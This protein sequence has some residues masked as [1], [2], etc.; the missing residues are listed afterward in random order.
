MQN[1]PT[2]G[3]SAC[4]LGRK[5]RYNGGDV[6]D[7]IVADLLAKYVNFVP[8]CPEVGIGLPVPREPIRLVGNA[9]D[10]QLI[11]EISG[12]DL[13]TTMKNWVKSEVQKLSSYSICGFIFKRSSPSC[14]LNRVRLWLKYSGAKNGEFCLRM[15]TGMFARAV[16]D[17]FSFV[18]MV[19]EDWLREIKNVDGFLERVFLLWRLKKAVSSGGS[20][21]LD[22]LRDFNN[23][24][25][26]I[27]ISRSPKMAEELE[28]LL[29]RGKISHYARCGAWILAVPRSR[30][31]TV[32]GFS[33]MMNE[34][35]GNI[36]KHTCLI[37]DSLIRLYNNSKMDFISFREKFRNT[38]NTHNPEHHLLKQYIFNPHP[39]DINA[40]LNFLS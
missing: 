23:R 4:L 7:R 1:K 13:T 8:F 37:L 29:K 14:G 5:C 26:Y 28:N 15:G 36:D 2:V 12:E 31:Y 21:A 6:R 40:I 20:N 10:P 17:S 30:K 34:I 27:F 16:R 24:A 39:V 19:Q 33:R 9:D 3:V 18:P 38:L 22:A 11:S 25:R 32:Y 35:E